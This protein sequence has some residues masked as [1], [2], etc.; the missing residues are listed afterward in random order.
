M[1]NLPVYSLT[2]PIKAIEAIGFA[3]NEMPYKIAA[4]VIEDIRRQMAEQEAS[5]AAAQC[6]PQES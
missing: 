6:Q 5:F 2:L 4:P 1:S 3:L